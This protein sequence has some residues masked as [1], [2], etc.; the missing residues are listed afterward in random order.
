MATR[1]IS[2][3]RAKLFLGD[4]EVGF[5]VNV[6]GT[7][8]QMLQRIDAM[9]DAYSKEIVAVRRVA[10]FTAAHVRI[11]NGSLKALGAMARG[12]TTNI[13]NF[14]PLTALLYDDLL[15]E[16]IEKITG[17]VAEQRSWS[18]DAAG[19][20]NENVSFQAIRMKDED[21]E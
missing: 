8:T 19:I 14:P 4:T 17:C 10:S 16:P 2:G 5:A 18:V 7:E 3:S 9:G 20:V 12:S 21:E 15:D 11:K 1:A 13:L 6:S